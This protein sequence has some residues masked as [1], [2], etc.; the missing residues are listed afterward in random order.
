MP[1]WL[2]IM[3]AIDIVCAIIFLCMIPFAMEVGQD[4]DH[5]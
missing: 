2:A 4:Y 5:W 1:H 3:L